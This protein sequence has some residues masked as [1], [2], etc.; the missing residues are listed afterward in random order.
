M[1]PEYRIGYANPQQPEISFPYEGEPAC[2]TLLAAIE[3]AKAHKSANAVLEVHKSDYGQ[4]RD[5]AYV[6]WMCST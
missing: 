5:V 2:E 3:A 4:H 1:R 6:R